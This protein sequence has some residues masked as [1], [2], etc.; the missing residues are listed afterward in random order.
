MKTPRFVFRYALVIG[1]IA[2]LW[3][4]A[5]CAKKEPFEKPPVPVKVYTITAAMPV[6]SLKYSATLVPREQVDLAFKVGGYVEDILKLPGP[7]G[8]LRDVQKGER[9][10]KSAI[11]AR[12]RDTDYQARL[13]HANSS[14]EEARASLAQA[15]LEFERYEKLFQ[16]DALSKNEHDKFKQKLEVAQARLTGAESQVEQAKIDLQDTILRSPLDALMVNRLVERGTL[17]APGTRAFV[18]QDLS[19]VKAVFGVPDYVLEKVKPGDSLAIT[20]EAL[21][22]KEF[23]GTIT[24]VSP[25]ADQRSRVFEVEITVPNPDL[26]LKD[27]MIGTV[28]LV[29]SGRDEVVPVIPVHAVVRPPSD[30]QGYMVFVLENQG[31]TYVARGRQVT[32]GKVFGN[33]VIIVHGLATG[34]Q[35]ITTGATTVSDGSPVNVIP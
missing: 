2:A 15:I 29:G 7:D 3:T 9:V 6:S 31:G 13:N 28:K 8:T 32:I 20:M 14:V 26:E 5:G 16:A 24:A 25:S 21:Q 4:V 33:K 12:I 30:P 10:E 23:R 1:L 19:S 17:V 34:E 18:L 27:G 35:V 11:L 22:D